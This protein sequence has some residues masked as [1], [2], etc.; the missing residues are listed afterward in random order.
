MVLEYYTGG[1]LEDMFIYVDFSCIQWGVE[2]TVQKLT[3]GRKGS[4]MRLS[5]QSLELIRFFF[6]L[7]QA[8]KKN[9]KPAARIDIKYNLQ[10]KFSSGD[11]APLTGHSKFFSIIP[12]F[13]DL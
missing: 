4:T 12:N 13:L 5:E 2:D 8:D 6:S 9:F 3:N 11:P 10:T 7:K 1:R